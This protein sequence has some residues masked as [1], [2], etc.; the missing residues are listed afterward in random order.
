VF[1]KPLLHGLDLSLYSLTKYVG[2]HS[3]LIGGAVVGSARAVAPVRTLRSAMGTQL[4]PHSCWMLGRSLETLGLRVGRASETARKVAA[5]LEEHPR[6]TAVHALFRLPE[7]TVARRVFERQCTGGGST[8]SVEVAG[9]QPAAF[10]LLN[11][12]RIFK[13]AVSLGGTESLASHPGST[14][15]SGVD[16]AVRKRMGV[17]EGLVRFSIGV[18]H[19]DDL[20]ADLAQALNQ[21]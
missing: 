21:T 6:I 7:G 10:R 2:G 19:E 1:Q 13:L 3:D 18:E 14:T 5:F 11:A 12:L 4:D 17:T 9:G 15:H 20:V 16:P 8:F